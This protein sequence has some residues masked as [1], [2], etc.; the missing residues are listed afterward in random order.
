MVPIIAI[1]LSSL[2]AQD[3]ARLAAFVRESYT[4]PDPD[5]VFHRDLLVPKNRY[6]ALADV[7]SVAVFPRRCWAFALR[8]GHYCYRGIRGAAA[9]VPLAPEVPVPTAAR[10]L[11]RKAIGDE[12]DAIADDVIFTSYIEGAGVRCAT[13]FTRRLEVSA[14]DMTEELAWGKSDFGGGFG[15]QDAVGRLAVSWALTY[16]RP[17]G[18]WFFDIWDVFSF[19]SA[20]YVLVL[21]STFQEECFA[22]EA[23]R[24]GAGEAKEPVRVSLGC[25]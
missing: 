10:G 2:M 11:A 21:S 9:V 18:E 3:S 8:D 22:L 12:Y 13:F 6:R 19:D 15:C 23:Y 17:S 25:I 5:T 1:V 4:V 20:V 7:D 16:T 24:L 14:K